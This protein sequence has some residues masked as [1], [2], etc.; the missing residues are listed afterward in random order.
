MVTIGSK[1]IAG[2]D[3]VGEGW[4]AEAPNIIHWNPPEVAPL[5]DTD[6]HVSC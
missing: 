5:S 1:A 6:G 3:P 2:V 4:E